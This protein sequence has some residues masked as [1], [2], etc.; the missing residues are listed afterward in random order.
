MW[1]TVIQ[2]ITIGQL[3]SEK[4]QTMISRSDDVVNQ[5]VANSTMDKAP[6]QGVG[7]GRGRGRL[8]CNTT[9]TPVSMTHCL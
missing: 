2:F 6:I 7:G 9:H 1:E 4:A 5:A 3:S 8:S